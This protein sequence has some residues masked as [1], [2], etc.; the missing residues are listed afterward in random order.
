MYQ[1]R[2]QPAQLDSSVGRGE[3]PIDF[4]TGHIAL[5]CPRGRFTGQRF[6][7]ADALC[8]TLPRQHGQF[9][10]GHVQP[11]GVFWRVM[12]F[13]ALGDPP[14]LLGGKAFVKRP[15]VVR[16]QVIGHQRGLRPQPN[17]SAF[18]AVVSIRRESCGKNRSAFLPTQPPDSPYLIGQYHEPTTCFS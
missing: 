15:E 18:H 14:S 6:R 8:Q 17:N 12:P 2:I 16:I 10:L 4:R 9:D 7:V 3:L 11:A 1:F 5:L 13:Q